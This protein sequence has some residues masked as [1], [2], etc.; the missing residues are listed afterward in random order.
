MAVTTPTLPTL[1]ESV[2][3]DLESQAPWTLPRQA[4][5]PWYYLARTIAGVTWGLYKLIEFV[6]EQIL[7][8]TATADNLERHAALYGLSRTAAA[9]ATGNVEFTGTNSTAIPKGTPLQ[10]ADGVAYVTTA[11]GTISGGLATVAVRA[12][13]GGTAGNAAE[14][15]ELTVGV[16]IAG[17]DGVATVAS[18]G[19]TGGTA[20]ETD[21]SL[22]ERVLAR[23][24]ATPQGGAESDYI[25]WAQAALS[26]VDEVWVLTGG[27]GPGTVTVYFTVDG[28]SPVPSGG[29]VSTVQAYIEPLA[30]VT[31]DVTVAAVVAKTINFTISVK[32]QSG[33]TNTEVEDAIK[34]ELD[35]MFRRYADVATGGYV[36]LSQIGGAISAAAGEDYHTIA[37]PAADVSCAVGEYPVRGTL[38]ITW[39]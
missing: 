28:V 3:A 12:V 1:I 38:G 18:G 37:A 32:K 9:K 23:L 22:R 15:E 2:T 16:V 33:Y 19:L 13:Q 11:A 17:L 29:N 10:R 34:A 30:P 24:S 27:S 7:P 14:D 5:S 36:R 39:L 31:A 25:A 35:A 20:E 6:A 8:D 4:F 21:A 26:T